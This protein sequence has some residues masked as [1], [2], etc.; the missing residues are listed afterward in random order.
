[1]ILDIKSTNSSKI[2]AMNEK[3]NDCDCRT[4]MKMLRGRY[5]FIYANYYGICNDGYDDLDELEEEFNGDEE[6]DYHSYN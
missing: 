4:Y 2:K 6:N 3:F 5:L 1:M